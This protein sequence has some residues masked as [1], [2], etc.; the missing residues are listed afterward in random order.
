MNARKT[1]AALSLALATLIQACAGPKVIANYDRAAD[2]GAY[3]TYGFSAQL[4]TDDGDTT[5]LLSKFLKAAATREL[6]ARGYTASDEPDLVVNFNVS[7]QQKTE[8]TE[9]PTAYYGY[10]RYGW[11]MGGAYETSVR[12]YTEGTLNVDLVDRARNELVWEGAYVGVVTDAMRENL[13]QTCDEAVA[14]VFG[15]Y[16]FVAGSGEPREP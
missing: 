12:Q 15:A 9:T 4:A 11:G 13:Q 7:S 5:T 10:R 16:P 6:E 8:V 2:F 14:E 1:T 3:R